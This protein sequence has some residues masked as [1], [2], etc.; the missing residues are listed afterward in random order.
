MVPTLS[1]TEFFMVPQ[2]PHLRRHQF[3][4]GCLPTVRGDER[5][6][7][8]KW[9]ALCFSVDKRELAPADQGLTPNMFHA[10]AMRSVDPGDNP[11]FPH[12][13]RILHSLLFQ[14]GPPRSSYALALADSRRL[15]HSNLTSEG[16]VRC[17]IKGLW[18]DAFPDF[19]PVWMTSSSAIEIQCQISVDKLTV[20]R[21][22]VHVNDP[23]PDA[24]LR[25]PRRVVRGTPGHVVLQLSPGGENIIQGRWVLSSVWAWQDG[26][27]IAGDLVPEF[28]CAIPFYNELVPRQ[29]PILSAG[30][31]VA[32]P[33]SP[34]AAVSASSSEPRPGTV[35]SRMQF[36]EGIDR[37]E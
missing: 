22:V 24:D 29:L 3:V 36:E 30:S 25:A 11:A 23:P 37:F 31:P 5:Q 10:V 2:I 35:R 13:P 12:H 19:V 18:A 21:A 15:R 27:A 9:A 20:S 16:C 32:A 33:R 28:T 34:V 1:D 7:V 14:V 17:A 8:E 26:I 6:V 4:P